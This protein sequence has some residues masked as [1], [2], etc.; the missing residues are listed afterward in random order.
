M[1]IDTQYRTL[2]NNDDLSFGGVARG[3]VR[4]ARLRGR[5]G[6]AGG[7]ASR[8]RG[9]RGGSNLFGQ[10]GLTNLAALS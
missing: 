8:Q 4:G 1:N 9:N 2:F 3:Q 10:F 6:F 5:Q 7:R